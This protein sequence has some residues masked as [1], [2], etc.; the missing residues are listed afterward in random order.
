MVAA[1]DVSLPLDSLVDASCLIWSHAAKNLFV[2]GVFYR[3]FTRFRVNDDHQA[4][5]RL[6]VNEERA[7]AKLISVGLDTGL[8]VHILRSAL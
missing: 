6:L 3:S 5:P 7:L 4:G 2:Q 8:S 1:D